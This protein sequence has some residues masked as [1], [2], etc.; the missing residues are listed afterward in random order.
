MR[1]EEV[2]LA[3]GKMAQDEGGIRHPSLLNR[4]HQRRR[5]LEYE[6]QKVNNSIQFVEKNTAIVEAVEVVLASRDK[7][8]PRPF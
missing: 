3:M 5:E 1:P 8:D 2:G 4:L 6:L 7:C